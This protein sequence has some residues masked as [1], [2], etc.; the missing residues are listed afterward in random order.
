AEPIRA[1]QPAAAGPASQ[2]VLALS[3]LMIGT[4]VGAGLLYAI[5]SLRGFSLN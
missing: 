3:W 5:A 2:F 4:V 1:A